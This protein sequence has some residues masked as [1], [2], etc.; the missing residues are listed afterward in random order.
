MSEGTKSGGMSENV[1]KILALRDENIL[2]AIKMGKK[3]VVDFWGHKN[4]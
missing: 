3:V 2:D 4:F 1:C